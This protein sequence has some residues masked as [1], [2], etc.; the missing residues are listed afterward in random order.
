M[1]TLNRYWCIYSTRHNWIRQIALAIALLS[2]LGFAVIANAQ[3][4]VTTFGIQL[5]PIVP[6]KFVGFET[7]ASESNGFTSEWEPR[8]S[9]SFGMVIR[10]GLT[11]S[12]SIESGINLLRRN[13]RVKMSE[14]E[15]GLDAN[16]DYSFVGYELPVQLLFYV[17]LSDRWWMNGS[18][19][20]SIDTYPSNT[21][22]N[23]S[24][25]ID[26][27]EYD[28]EQFT[29]RRKWAQIAVQANYGFEYRTK[30]S[31]YYYLGVTF[32]RPFGTMANSESVLFY[33]EA[34]KRNVVELNGT[35][36]TVDLRYFFHEKADQKKARPKKK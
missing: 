22:S 6:N 36:F 35:Y 21:F 5:R 19:G 3:E 15:N 17:P 25:R 9:L 2:A 7:V 27:V 1:D 12:I 34:I 26:T 4:N 14:P 13:Y 30:E 18:G 31:G 24:Q 16:I 10:W 29:A 20:L 11:K 8:P 32:H 33:S 28:F 23:T